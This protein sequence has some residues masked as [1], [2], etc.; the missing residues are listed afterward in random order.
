[1]SGSIVR[2]TCLGNVFWEMETV[3]VLATC[4]REME[5]VGVCNTCLRDAETCSVL[6]HRPLSHGA[7]GVSLTP[8]FILHTDRQSF[9]AL[10]QTVSFCTTVQR[11]DFSLPHG[12]QRD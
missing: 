9:C 12:L 10:I 2:K 11:K 1:M 5:T 6:G 4:L 8:V 7:C 3:G